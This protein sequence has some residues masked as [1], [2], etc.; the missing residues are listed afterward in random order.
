MEF[1]VEN[2]L[3]FCIQELLFKTLEITL[4]HTLR[5]AENINK[6]FKNKKLNK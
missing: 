5:K 6:C 1:D 2:Y 3:S 4:I